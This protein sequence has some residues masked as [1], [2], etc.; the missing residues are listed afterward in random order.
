M[1]AREGISTFTLIFTLAHHTMMLV[2]EPSW[3]SDGP[4]SGTTKELT[5][6]NCSWPTSCTAKE[7]IHG[8]DTWAEIWLYLQWSFRALYDGVHPAVC[9]KG[10]PFEPGSRRRRLAGKKLCCLEWRAFIM[11]V[12]GDLDFFHKDLWM[13]GHRAV[14]VEDN[15]IHMSLGLC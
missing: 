11:A 10:R 9:F 12:L 13:P 7:R 5:H 4:G 15:T 2:H 3:C 6:W 1:V 8:I 14:P